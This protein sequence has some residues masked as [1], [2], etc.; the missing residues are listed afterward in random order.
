MTYKLS[1]RTYRIV[2]LGCYGLLVLFALLSG[3]LYADVQ[4]AF[5]FQMPLIASCD[6]GVLGG[7]ALGLAAGPLLS[8]RERGTAPT[9]MLVALGCGLCAA[10]M[11]RSGMLFDAAPWDTVAG[12]AL[13]GFF[14]SLTGCL[15][16]TALLPLPALEALAVLARAL[17]AA[18]GAFIVVSLLPQGCILLV[19]S[20]L[21]PVVSC[22]C[23]GRLLPSV[24]TWEKDPLPEAAEV[25]A[26][27]ALGDDGD[28]LP[29]VLTL[30]IVGSMFVADLL[31]SLFPVS[32]YTETSPLFAPLTGSAEAPALGNLTEPAFIAAVI[33]LAFAGLLAAMA[34]KNT[35]KLPVLCALGFFLVAVGFVTFPY[36]M[37]GGAPIGIAEAGECIIVLFAL[38]AVRSYVKADSDGHL[39]RATLLLGLKV[40]AAMVVADLLVIVLY[41]LPFFDYIDFHIRSVLSGIGVLALVGLLVG[42]MP[43][44]YAV[45]DGPANGGAPTAP[46]EATASAEDSA[47]RALDAF[48]ERYR[49]SPRE[50]EITGLISK[51]RD[52]PYI[53]QELVLSKSTVKTHIRH[54]YE[55]CGVS[56]RQDLLDLL[57]AESPHSA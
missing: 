30:A 38:A 39:T 20:L 51:G 33:L 14:L 57:H 44:V 26:E 19:A 47:E 41:Q 23:L 52:V 54:I 55:K 50:R 17:G 16:W 25:A 24:D 29:R 5:G 15:W 46:V 32:L 21:A 34:R 37:P 43:R 1:K 13:F 10:V 27:S 28:A 12:D 4:T 48:A 7:F 31:M 45:V 8:D 53:E 56:S 36:H 9:G 11:L 22:G 18:C 3:A 2:G 42:L 35:L 40:A 49:L 6:I